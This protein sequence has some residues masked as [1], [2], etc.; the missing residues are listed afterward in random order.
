MGKNELKDFNTLYNEFYARYVRF[1]LSYIKDYNL[2]EDFVSEAFTL[3]WSNKNSLAENSNPRA[4]I[5]TIVKNKCLNHLQHLQV[6]RRAE[7]AISEHEMWR[8]S[9]NINSL[10]ACDPDFIFSAEI[11]ELIDATL[12]QMPTKTKEIFT[13]NRYEGLTYQEIAKRLEMSNKSIEYHMS[14]ALQTMRLSLKEYLPL[15]L[16]FYFY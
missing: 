11:R 7:K 2:S 6:R 4:Y 5:L 12:E 8:L 9:L 1:A 10:A 14:K 16:L 15:V 13:L 3:Y